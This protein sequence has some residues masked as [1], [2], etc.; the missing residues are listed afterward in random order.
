MTLS[1]NDQSLLGGAACCYRTLFVA[2]IMEKWSVAEVSE[3]LV[4]NDFDVEVV[5][6]FRRNKIKGRV[7]KLLTEAD[8]QEMGLTAIGDRRLLS[9]L[10]QQVYNYT[11]NNIII[12]HNLELSVCIHRISRSLITS[13][14]KSFNCVFCMYMTWPS[15]KEVR[16]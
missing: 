9:H 12:I 2:N 3:F 5:E 11:I 7:L 1:K 8:L 14:H 10:L 15:G 13:K 4:A 16:I 6:L